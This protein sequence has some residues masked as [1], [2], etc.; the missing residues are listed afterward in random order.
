MSLQHGSSAPMTPERDLLDHFAVI[1]A[2]VPAMLLAGSTATFTELPRIFVVTELASDR[3]RFQWVT[4]ATLVGGVIGMSSLGWLAGHLGLRRCFQIGLLLYTVGSAASSQA[5]GIDFLAV[6]RFV[7]SAGNGIVAT[8]VLALLWREFPQHRDQG[9]AVF[10]FCIY[11]G[12]IAAPS[13]S[14][15]LV[16][17]DSWRSIFYL[18]TVV[19]GF[20]LLISWRSLRPDAPRLEPPG[21]FDFAGLGLLVGW[22]VCLVIGLYR[23]QLWG[24]NRSN[25]TLIVLS[26]GLLLFAGFLCQ[27]FAV[28]RPL[29]ELKLLGRHHFAMGV[30]IKALIDGQFFTVLGILTRYMAI[31][32]DY[33]RATTGA[34]MLPSVAAMAITLG[35]TA[36]FGTR[37]NRKLRLVI[38]LVGMTLATW[39][40]SR[41]DL[42][43]P[44]EWISIVLAGWAASVGLVA[45]PV[46]CIAQDN[47]LPSEIANSAS[48][49]NLGLVLPGFLCGGL[50]AITTERAGDMYFDSLRQTIQTN[51]MPVGDVTSGLIDWITRTHGSTAETAELQSMQI[52]GRYVRSTAS[53]YADQTAFC[54][55]TMV[56][57]VALVLALM[58]RKLPPEAPGPQRG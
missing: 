50:I 39:Q 24:W 9:I 25:D 53:V 46:I 14:A 37:D 11:L 7:Q 34:V 16:D 31:T 28:A 12:R 51:R 1:L 42:F 49:K 26:L 19:S 32:R 55:L 45:S 10:A 44:K 5:H 4:G 41:I 54:W 36:H 40:L 38:G 17:H 21:G 43:T 2:I 20:S 35:V 3:Y 56:S 57:A 15:W 33:T 30:V 18:A 52:L 6:S 13:I 8:T 48:I 22:V 29:L 23:F 47:L 27:Q 58:L